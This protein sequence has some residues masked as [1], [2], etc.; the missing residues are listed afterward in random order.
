MSQSQPLTN[1][2]Q[3]KESRRSSC[4]KPKAS[5]FAW[6]F[7]T[8]ISYLHFAA[9]NVCAGRYQQLL[10]NSAMQWEPRSQRP[11]RP[12]AVLRSVSGL[13]GAA[14]KAASKQKPE[15]AQAMRCASECV[16][17][18]G[19]RLGSAM[20]LSNLQGHRAP[21]RRLCRGLSLPLALSGHSS[22]H[23]ALQA[24]G[25]DRRARPAPWTL[26]CCLL[27]DFP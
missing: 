1:A 22:G 8:F 20:C 23:L 10:K 11:A 9:P 7:D 14:P 6:S 15:S 25:L 16:A 24:G 18:R 27:V 5:A 21:A 12:D 26:S 17:K 2:V 19:D 13:P 4:T 3:T